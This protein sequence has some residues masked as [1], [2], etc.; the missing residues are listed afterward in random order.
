ML[1]A[2][3][4]YAP[5][6]S[7]ESVVKA[8]KEA[9]HLA[10][11]STQ[12]TIRTNAP[13]WQ[14]WLTFFLQS[15]AEQVRRLRGK[16]DREISLLATVPALPVAILELAREHGRATIGEAMHATG[17]G[18][19][20]LERHFR[21]LVDTGRLERHGHGRRV[22]YSLRRDQSLGTDSAWTELSAPIR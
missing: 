14:P 20:T 12:K 4:A 17:S 11:R 3:Y 18:R 2:G 10:L 8:N 1:Q 19:D 6:S 21:T 22:W 16:M 5:C 15:L 9:Y 7:L 13:D